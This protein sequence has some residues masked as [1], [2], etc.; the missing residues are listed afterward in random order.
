MVRKGHWNIPDTFVRSNATSVSVFRT[1]CPGSQPPRVPNHRFQ[2]I[3]QS[4]NKFIA[5]LVDIAHTGGELLVRR[6]DIAE[7]CC[8]EIRSEI[9]GVRPHVDRIGPLSSD[10]FH[11]TVLQQSGATFFTG[12]VPGS[13]LDRVATFVLHSGTIFPVQHRSVECKVRSDT[14]HLAFELTLLHLSLDSRNPSDSRCIN[15]YFEKV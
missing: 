7:K 1:L 13:H 12:T 3:T 11:L 6:L 9:V 10:V 5:T 8:A 2:S 14:F 4:S 15:Y